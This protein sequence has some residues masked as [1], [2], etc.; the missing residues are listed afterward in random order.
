MRRKLNWYLTQFILIVNYLTAIGLSQNE[1]KKIFKIEEVHTDIQNPIGIITVDEPFDKSSSIQHIVR[2]E[3]ELLFCDR[4]FNV[5]NRRITSINTKIISSKKSWYLLLE[6]INLESE[7]KTIVGQMEIVLIDYNGKEYWSKIIP[8]YYNEDYSIAYYP[9]DYNGIVF[10]F[11]SENSTLTSISKNGEVLNKTEL[12]ENTKSPGRRTYLDI[13]ESGEYCVILSEIR[14]SQEK[15]L[16][17]RGRPGK[18]IPIPQMQINKHVE[19]TLRYCERIDGEPTLFLFDYNGVLLRKLRVEEEQ[20]SNVFISDDGSLILYAVQDIDNHNGKYIIA[21][22][23]NNFKKLFS[24]SIL[25]YPMSLLFTQNS[26]ILG[27]LEKGGKKY[28]LLSVDKNSGAEFWAKELKNAP[29]SFFE[30][31]NQSFEIINCSEATIENPLKT[32]KNYWIDKF[33]LAGNLLSQIEIGNIENEDIYSIRYREKHDNRHFIIN[34][35]I[36]VLKKK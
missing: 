19:D 28:K 1:Q 22:V 16:I 6:N 17:G 34:K 14:E 2:T 10:S 31:D 24:K 27:H 20:P 30:T 3:Q 18:P 12:F 9:I 29:I 8:I 32:L 35:K 13:S 11:D 15:V 23:D 21:L 5:I 25:G 33:D 36:N 7:K 26:I 4:N